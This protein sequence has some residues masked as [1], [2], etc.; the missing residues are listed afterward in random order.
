MK[1]VLKLLIFLVAITV[2]S[3]WTFRLEMDTIY[4]G[5]DASNMIEEFQ[6]YGLNQTTM[7]VVGIFKVMCAIFLLLGLK[8]EKL[9]SPAAFVMGTFMLAAIYFHI[10]ISDPIIPT[11][12][13]AVMFLSCAAI[14][15]LDKK[16]SNT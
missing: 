2:L 15:Y 12:P 11:V 7:I 6:A 3:A 5:A 14:I 4:R 16:F 13:S 1:I 8:F 9:V 10:S